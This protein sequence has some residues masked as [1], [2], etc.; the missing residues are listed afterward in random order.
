VTTLKA[1]LKIKKARFLTK[2]ILRGEIEK[3]SQYK[4]YKTKKI[5]IKRIGTKF[6][7]K[8]N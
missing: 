4:K 8:I 6:N 5:A 1:K 2:Q 7:I 3:K